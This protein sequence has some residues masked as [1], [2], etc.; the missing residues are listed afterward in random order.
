MLEELVGTLVWLAANGL[1]LDF[2]RKGRKGCV[3]I[4]FFWM[5]IPATLLW[6]FLVP[7]GKEPE[8]PP[9]TDDY[10]GLLD[11]I[12]RE[13]A[14]HSGEDPSGARPPAG[15]EEIEED[16]GPDEDPGPAVR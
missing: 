13:K 8:L 4:I 16:E 15:R 11:E 7:E 1:Y 3:R 6:L 5:G 2:R 14:L 10:E 9:P 12:R